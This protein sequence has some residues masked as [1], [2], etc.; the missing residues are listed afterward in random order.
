MVT[1][2]QHTRDPVL[3]WSCSAPQKNMWRVWP[4]ENHGDGHRQMAVMAL[5]QI[6]PGYFAFSNLQLIYVL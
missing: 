1:D 3:F 6:N 2:M 4:C 5:H